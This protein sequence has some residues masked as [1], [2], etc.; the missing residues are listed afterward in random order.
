MAEQDD[1]GVLS[2]T[3]RAWAEEGLRGEIRWKW[4]EAGASQA[5]PTQG[6]IPTSLRGEATTGVSGGDL[7]GAPFPSPS[8]I[9]SPVPLASQRAIPAPPRY[10]PAPRMLREV[11]SPE[12]WGFQL[13]FDH[14]LWQILT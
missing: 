2:S 5:A 10:V 9:P 4:A 13:V 14:L 6:T 1:G 7:G 3:W 11:S 8:H 12:S